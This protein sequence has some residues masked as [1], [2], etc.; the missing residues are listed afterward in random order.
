[1]LPFPLPVAIGLNPSASE[2]NPTQVECIGHVWSRIPVYRL[3]KV[4]FDLKDLGW[5]DGVFND[6]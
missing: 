3:Q 6:I 4:N 5:E 1:M 2:D